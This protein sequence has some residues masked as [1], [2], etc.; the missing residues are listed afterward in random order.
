M[1]IVL[2]IVLVLV[3]LASAVYTLRKIRKSQML[4]GD[5]I[6]WVFLSLGLL[7]LSAFPVIATSGAALIGIESPANFVYLAIFFFI[8]I[9]LFTLSVDVS[10]QKA[11]LNTAIQKFTIREAGMSEPA[12][13]AENDENPKE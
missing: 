2:R 3:S 6:Y 8:I 11:K 9:K 4:I 7:V 1:N 13:R 5:A 12:A 10:M